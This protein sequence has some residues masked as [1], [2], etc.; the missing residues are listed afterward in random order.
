MDPKEPLNEAAR[1]IVSAQSII[2]D[3][4][5]QAA[6]I[7]NALRRQQTLIESLTGVATWGA[8][9]GAE[10]EMPP[11]EEPEEPEE[12]PEEPEPEEQ[13]PVEEP[14]EEEPTDA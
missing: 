2:A 14:E 9:S 3:L 8:V 12:E 13:A 10:P 11:E 4:T 1:L 6:E 5:V 7:Q